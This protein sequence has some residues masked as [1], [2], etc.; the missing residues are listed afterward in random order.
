MQKLSLQ[1]FLQMLNR[2]ICFWLC[3]IPGTRRVALT[4]LPSKQLTVSRSLACSPF[5]TQ[6]HQGQPSW[7]EWILFFHV[8]RFPLNPFHAPW[9]CWGTVGASTSLHGLLEDRSRHRPFPSPLHFQ[10]HLGLQR[11][12]PPEILARGCRS[13]ADIFMFNNSCAESSVFITLSWKVRAEMMLGEGPL[14][15]SFLLKA[16]SQILV[17]GCLRQ[18]ALFPGKEKAAFPIFNTFLL[19]VCVDIKI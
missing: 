14:R 10:V 2:D 4:S 15:C 6:P 9:G 8:P 1:F 13:Y 18:I 11:A 5:P 12:K 3:L 17:S 19:F 16:Y 7:D